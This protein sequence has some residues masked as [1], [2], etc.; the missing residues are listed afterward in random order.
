MRNTAM[1]QP[2]SLRTTRLHQ[3]HPV[4][5]P[6]AVS[7][8]ARPLHRRQVLRVNAA[9]NLNV[10]GGSSSVCPFLAFQD[11][12]QVASSTAA[13]AE[14]AAIRGP[15]WRPAP[16]NP[17]QLPEPQGRWCF[18]PLVGEYMELEAK[19]AGP[20]LLERFRCALGWLD[21]G[22]GGRGEPPRGAV[23]GRAAEESGVLLIWGAQ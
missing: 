8:R 2:Q 20:F 1:A 18:N 6:A 13:A 10:D 12:G 3:L 5:S 7:F 14:L 23:V 4:A 19:G 9:A 11:R 22:A 17:Q 21:G 16:G 15:N